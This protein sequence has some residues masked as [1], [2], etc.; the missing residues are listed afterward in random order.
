MTKEPPISIIAKIYPQLYLVP[1]EPGSAEAYKE[2]VL[3]GAPAPSTDLSHFTMNEEDSIEIMDTP[4][5]KV[6]VLT[7][8]ERRDFELC[9]QI[10]AHKCIPYD[11]P[12]TQGSVILDGLVNWQKIRDHKKA[13]IEEKINKGDLFPDWSEEFRRF[14]SVRDNYR[15]VLIILSA[16]PYS[17]VPASALGLDEAEWK[18][19]SMVIRK[20]HEATHFICRRM[21]PDKISAVWDE[22]VADAVGI[23]AARGTFEPEME[24]VFLGTG[25]DGYSGGRLE[26]YAAFEKEKM[27]ILAA[28]IYALLLKIRGLYESNKGVSPFE[29]ALIMEEKQDEWEIRI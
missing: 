23:I 3:Q 5:G 7:L 22:I 1:G 16:G 19:T 24:A 14:T 12:A 27:D 17:N 10:L 8:C 20:Y 6:R 15:D 26:N 25:Q 11:V 13:W 29:F 18:K 2:I 28:K 9:L 4:A 21:Y